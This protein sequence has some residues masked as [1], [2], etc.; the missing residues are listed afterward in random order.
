[1]KNDRNFMVSQLHQAKN[2]VTMEDNRGIMG[3]QTCPLLN[4]MKK[5]PWNKVDSIKRR[6]KK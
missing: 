5:N 1:M 3:T 2:G 4:Q 6:L